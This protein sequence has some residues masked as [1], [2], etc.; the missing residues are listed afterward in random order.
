MVCPEPLV[1]L[2]A[3]LPAVD[4]CRGPGE[5]DKNAFHARISLMSLPLVFDTHADNIPAVTPYLTVP[6]PN[7]PALPQGKNGGLKVGIVW[8][9]NP[10]Q[11]NNYLRSCAI[12]AFLPLLRVP[13]VDFYSLQKGERAQDLSG[14]PED[15][16][17]INLDDL[18]HDYADTAALVQQLDL[19]IS[20]D[21]SVAHLAAALNRP[22]W[23]LV[24]YNADWRYPRDNDSCPW[25]PSM[26]LFW[27]AEPMQWQFVFEQV[28]QALTTLSKTE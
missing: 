19:V 11:A 8:A 10:E 21:T 28:A 22:T 20:V 23:V 26:R 15:V 12:D 4:E 24:Y 1:R 18:I 3:K 14:L 17:V 9:G 16:S 6:T 5:L 25:Y 13:G 27:Q 2:F 7:Q